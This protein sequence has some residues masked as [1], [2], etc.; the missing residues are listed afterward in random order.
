MCEF[1][2]NVYYENAIFSPDG[3]GILLLFSLESKR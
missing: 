1:N 3:N 2:H